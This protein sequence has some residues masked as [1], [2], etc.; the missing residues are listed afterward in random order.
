MD[1][2]CLYY[3]VTVLIKYY[4]RKAEQEKTSKLKEQLALR[5]SEF[6]REKDECTKMEKAM[7]TAKD[8][9]SKFERTE[10]QLQQ[11]RKHLKGKK[12]TLAENIKKEEKTLS[13]KRESIESQTAEV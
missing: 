8:N 3:E 4:T 9:W 10:I 1:A 13:Q 6:K 5:E 2:C 11:D 7:T 12:K